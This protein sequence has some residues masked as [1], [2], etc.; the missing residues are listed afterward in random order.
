VDLAAFQPFT[1]SFV[2][3]PS[4]AFPAPLYAFG[5]LGIPVASDEL[6][7]SG[8]GTLCFAPPILNPA[9]PRLFL[10]S[11]SFFSPDPAALFPTSPLGSWSVPVPSG[12]PA[13]FVVALSGVTADGILY[14][15][16]TVLLNVQ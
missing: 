1:I 8:L 12:L 16:N 13:P 10:F 5:L 4:F 6:F 14:R 15:T 2:Q 3:P 11:D 7:V 9:D